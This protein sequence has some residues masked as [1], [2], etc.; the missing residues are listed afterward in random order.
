VI[1]EFL[2]L[3]IANILKNMPKN[4]YE[5]LG[6]SK[7]ATDDEIKKA[8]RKMA[9]QYHPDKSGG[10][11][12]KFKELNEAYQVLSDK[13][14]RGQYDQYGQTFEQAG[15][16]G[17]GF[18]GGFEGFDF[19]DIFSRS[20]FSN[21]GGGFEDIFSDI[22]GSGSAQGGRRR[23]GQGQDIQVDLEI[24]FREMVN[25]VEKEIKLYKGVIC[26][27]CHGSGGDP[28]SGQEN[29]SHCGGTGQIKKTTRSFFGVFSQV[30]VC[31][32]CQGA[33]QIF[34]KKCSQCG[35]D[36]RVKEENR[37]RIPIPAGIE[38]RQT[39][40][41]EGQGEAG[42][43]GVAPGDLYITVRIE[44]DRKFSR[45]GNDVLSSEKIPFSVATLGG[46]VEVETLEEK[47]ILKIPPGTQSGEIFRLK[48]SGIYFS[49]GRARGNQLI[50]IIVEIPKRVN[51]R[52]EELLRELKE[53]GL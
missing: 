51:R 30:S 20:G 35:G 32:Q 43:R 28:G 42:E 3:R 21:Q 46:K 29:C 2:F 26:R 50:K 41:L 49:Q 14:K 15:R 38:D 9:H 10:D 44:K 24:S 7:S 22:F 4:Y 11:E 45:Q 47:L 37:I 12:K 5:I 6:V 25:G 1:V 52:Q 8:Y 33:G 27:R 31:P 34:R 13:T 17:Q 36:G 39:L 53:E 48:N 19:N 18:S 23:R 16:S 40:V